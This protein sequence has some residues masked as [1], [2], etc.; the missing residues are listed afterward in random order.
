MNPE[1]LF[2]T[3]LDVTQR[4][5]LRVQIEDAIAAD[6]IFTTLMGDEVEPRRHFIESNA[7]VAR[8]I[9]V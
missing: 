9:D 6:Q 1:Q 4:R 3:T 7:L 8:N 5:L 2:E